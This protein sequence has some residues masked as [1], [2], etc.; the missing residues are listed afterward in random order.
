MRQKGSK[1]VPSSSS[2]L[3]HFVLLFSLFLYYNPHTLNRPPKK[4]SYLK[5][6]TPKNKQKNPNNQTHKTSP[7]TSKKKKGKKGKPSKPKPLTPK[8][9][10][11]IPVENVILCPVL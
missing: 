8:P 7:R 2:V 9:R 10:I 11:F 1:D 5:K 6:K 3:S 4:H